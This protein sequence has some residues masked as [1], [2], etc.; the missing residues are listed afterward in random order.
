MANLLETKADGSRKGGV[1][2]RDA[3]AEDSPLRD[4][5]K[6]CTCAFRVANATSYK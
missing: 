6:L 2:I 3:M 1:G 5:L 4:G